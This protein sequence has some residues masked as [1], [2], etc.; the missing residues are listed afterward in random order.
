MTNT[1]R[2]PLKWLGAFVLLT[3]VI[4]LASG[5]PTAASTVPPT[6]VDECDPTVEICEINGPATVGLPSTPVPDECWLGNN[7]STA[8]PSGSFTVYGDNPTAPGTHSRS[9]MACGPVEVATAQPPV[10]PA[11]VTLPETGAETWGIALVAMVLI[12]IGGGALYAARRS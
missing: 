7:P 2:N 5:T 4:A 1:Q 3:L 11:A 8:L 6:T 10:A 9:G 12:T